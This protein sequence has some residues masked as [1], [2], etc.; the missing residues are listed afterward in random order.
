MVKIKVDKYY[1][2][3]ELYPYIPSLVFDA[4]E[5]GY[6]DGKEYVEVPHY[7]YVEMCKNLNSAG[8]CL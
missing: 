4:L 7:A 2:N 8:I 1:A 6:L 5:A 3:T